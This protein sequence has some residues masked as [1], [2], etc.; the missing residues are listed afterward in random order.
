MMEAVV[1]AVALYF[2]TSVYCFLNYFFQRK[3]KNKIKYFITLTI[4]LILS[5]IK[6]EG[7]ALLVLIFLLLL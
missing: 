5:L 3:M 7:F 6:N 2:I 1:G 4:L